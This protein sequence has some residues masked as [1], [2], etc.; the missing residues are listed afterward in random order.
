MSEMALGMTERLKPIHERVARMVRDEIMPLDEEFLAEVGRGGDRWGFTPRQAEILDSLKARARERGLWNF[1]LTDS[2]RG[3]GLTT[4]EYAYLAEEMGKAH[5]GAETFNCSAPDTGNMEVLERYGNAEQK[6]RWLA[7]LLEGKIRSAYLMTE[8][9]VASSDATNIAMRC[10]RD[11]GHYVL[12]GEKWWASGAGDP[13]CKIYIVMVRTGGDD[14]PK[15]LR[16]SMVLVPADTPGITKLRAMLV[17]GDDDAPHGHMHLSFQNVRV[18]ASNFI[19]GE[20]RGFEIAQG[21]LGPGRI[22]HCMRAI[23]QAERALE[24][25]CTRALRREAF[26]RKLAEL[27]ANFDIIA[28][29]RMEIEMA[30]LLCL[31]AAWMIDQGDA[32]AAA[33]WISQIKVVAPRMAL[34][35]TD[36]AVQLFGAQGISQDTPLARAW[37][38]LRTLRLADGPDAVHRRQ[39]ARAE[40]RKYTQEKL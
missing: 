7:P 2:T 6:Q 30:R 4:V 14:V 11:G 10:E 21:R 37:T 23:G 34:K 22:H 13:R 26:G 5:L 28:E 27:G 16:H 36:E 35:V 19:L 12:N 38:H 39:I 25:M 17:Y 29:C 40:L 18:P 32:R 20:G 3:Y 1:W 31:K 15:H 9:D 33:P 8:P 24:L